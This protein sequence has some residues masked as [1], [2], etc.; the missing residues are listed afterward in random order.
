MKSS[1]LFRLNEIGGSISFNEIGV[2]FS[3]F[4]EKK[5]TLADFCCKK[6]TLAD[7]EMTFFS[8]FTY[9]NCDK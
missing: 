3:F 2:S 4:Y 8:L 5:H 7:F 1:F 9:Q 6:H